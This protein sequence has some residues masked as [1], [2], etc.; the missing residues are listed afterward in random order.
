MTHGRKH[1][2][3]IVRWG[4]ALRELTAAH[5]RFFQHLILTNTQM[6]LKWQVRL[7]CMILFLGL[8][9]EKCNN[10][11]I[12]EGARSWEEGVDTAEFF[13]EN[14]FQNSFTNDSTARRTGEWGKGQHP[15]IGSVWFVTNKRAWSIILEECLLVLAKKD[16]IKRF[17]VRFWNPLQ[18]HPSFFRCRDIPWMLSF[19]QHSTPP[20]CCNWKGDWVSLNKMTFQYEVKPVLSIVTRHNNKNL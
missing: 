4:E 18:I 17:H 15:L 14:Y 13:T 20:Y 12:F 19:R 11:N 10:K 9:G 16:S 7:W 1:C 2:T 3:G 5:V 8:Q 6:V